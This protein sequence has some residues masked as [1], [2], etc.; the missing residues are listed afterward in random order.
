MQKKQLF[1][2]FY[3]FSSIS[4]ISIT[5][6]KNISRYCDVHFGSLRKN[7][8]ICQKCDQEKYLSNVFQSRNKI[9]LYVKSTEMRFYI[10][11]WGSFKQPCLVVLNASRTL[12]QKRTFLALPLDKYISTL[13]SPLTSTV[14]WPKTSTA[15]CVHQSYL[16]ELM[17]EEM[18]EPRCSTFKW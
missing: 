3:T 16:I 10:S 2:R 18:Q 4:S 5:Q 6:R 14:S 1:F 13:V 12:Q 17:V 8:K 15:M 11:S 9:L 7:E